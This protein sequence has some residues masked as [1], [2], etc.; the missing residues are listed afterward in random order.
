MKIESDVKDD[1]HFSIVILD[2][3]Y[4]NR[5]PA[6]RR[7]GSEFWYRHAPRMQ[8]MYWGESRTV[9]EVWLIL[10]STLLDCVLLAP[11]PTLLGFLQFL[12]SLFRYQVQ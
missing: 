3:A 11:L 4:G 5:S 2:G 1:M 9:Q 10:V 6:S 12:F 7:T 8:E